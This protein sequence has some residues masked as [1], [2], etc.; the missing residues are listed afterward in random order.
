[1]PT[2]LSVANCIYAPVDSVQAGLLDPIFG[3][4]LSQAYVAE[5]IKRENSILSL[6]QGGK[7]GVPPSTTSLVPFP[8]HVWPRNRAT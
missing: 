8:R 7:A 1:M 5:L 4:S 2:D 3:S 6:R